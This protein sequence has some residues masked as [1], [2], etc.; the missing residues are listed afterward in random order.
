MVNIERYHGMSTSGPCYNG[1]PV[2]RWV[3]EFN[4]QYYGKFKLM[5]RNFNAFA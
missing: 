4:N 2:F 1:I 5:A 3:L